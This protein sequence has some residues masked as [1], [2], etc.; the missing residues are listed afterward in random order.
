MNKILI[1][2]ELAK[3]ALILLLPVA[4]L[5]C[6]SIDEDRSD[7]GVYLEFKYEHNM[8]YADAFKSQVNSVDVLF[9]GMDNRY[10]LT[11]HALREELIEENKIF[12]GDDPIFARCKILTIGGLSDEFEITDYSGNPP[13]PG[14]TMLEDIQLSLKHSSEIVSDEF[15][16]I[17]MAPVQTIEYKTELSTWPV[18]LIRETNQF[19]IV[20]TNNK[21]VENITNLP[22][23]VE[24][25]TPEWGIYGYDNSPQLKEQLTYTPYYLEPG[26]S[27]TEVSVARIKTMR[28]LDMQGYDYR[29]K[30]RNTQTN[31][32]VWEED[33][34]NLIKELKRH[35][36]DG[37]P[38]SL[39][40][41]LDRQNEWNFVIKFKE[42][43]F[44]DEGFIGIQVIVNNW[45]VWENKIGV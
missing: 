28:L 9:F 31:K 44:G 11:K 21:Q 42:E 5:S 40:E 1:H 22:Y 12:L 17:W 4:L 23:T 10:L 27:I 30:V 2:N 32:I 34:I 37:N 38:M 13:T 43:E 26:E 33:L 16:N 35:S 45:I 29:L 18:F 25:D 8:E 15:Q 14:T 3:L 39:Q 36:P 41:F 20:L 6:D 19:N 24:I 7:C